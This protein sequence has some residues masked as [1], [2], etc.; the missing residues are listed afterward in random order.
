[1]GKIIKAVVIAFLFFLPLEAQELPSARN[2]ALS[3]S[4]ISKTDNVFSLF[5]N[6]AAL[7]EI[8][9]AQA[10]IYYSPAPFGLN[11]L[12]VGYLG[13]TFP[14]SNFSCGIGIMDYGYSLYKENAVYLSVAQKYFNKT[15]FGISLVYNWFHIKNYGSKGTAAL[16]MG[17]IIP[18]V[19][20]ID[21][22]ISVENIKMSGINYKDSNL[23]LKIKSGL[24]LYIDEFS[25]FFLIEKEMEY[26][27]VFC[28]G[29]EYYPIDIVALRVGVGENPSRISAGIGIIYKIINVNFALSSHGD[30]GQTQSLDLI[31]SIN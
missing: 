2:N 1:M 28:F 6:P 22:A 30:L 11:E 17:I 5:I 14:T 7:C 8:K 27:P 31:I 25:L 19:D 20:F 9:S 15:N 29:L 10:G 21:F 24:N 16:N 3:N 18:L 26:E 23:P 4:D 12:S 13:L